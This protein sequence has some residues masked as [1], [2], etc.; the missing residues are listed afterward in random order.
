MFCLY[1]RKN[2]G[3]YWLLYFCGLEPFS[4][5]RS[6]W[7][8]ACFS[9]LCMDREWMCIP[10]TP[11]W[12]TVALSFNL[13]YWV[14]DKWKLK[15]V[16]FSRPK[17]RWIIISPLFSLIVICCYQKKIEISGV[18]FLFHIP[19]KHIK[20]RLSNFKFMVTLCNNFI[21]VLNTHIESLMLNLQSFATLPNN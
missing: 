11:T 9:T 18:N 13:V 4:C 19:D 16:A 17:C 8:C 12:H 7:H 5:R 2:G 3:I 15:P 14:F 6:C 10:D 21:N 20:S 1:L